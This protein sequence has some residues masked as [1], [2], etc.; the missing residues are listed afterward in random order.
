[1]TFYLGCPDDI[2]I[3]KNTN[4]YIVIDNN[5]RVNLNRK[6]IVVPIDCIF[7]Y[8][9]EDENSYY[10]NVA[11]KMRNAGFNGFMDWATKCIN[12]FSNYTYHDEFDRPI[13]YDSI[14]FISDNEK[15]KEY[16]KNIFNNFGFS[17]NNYSIKR[18]N[19]LF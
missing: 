11:H 6:N 2:R 18:E 17:I 14:I 16:I 1:M 3:N 13:I 19:N 9:N 7:S 12:D 8:N 15:C 10:K 4:L 5:Y